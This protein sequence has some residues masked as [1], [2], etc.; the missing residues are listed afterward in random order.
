MSSN[1]ND[2]EILLA[3]IRELEQE[4]HKLKNRALM[5]EENPERVKM[6]KDINQLRQIEQEHGREIYYDNQ[7]SMAK[8]VCNYIVS[9]CIIFQLVLA[10]PQTGK[11]GCML[12]IIELLL[13]METN[14][15]PENIF[16]ITGLSDNEWVAQ[17]RGR[18]PLPDYNVIHRGQFNRSK[19]LFQNLENAV[20]FIDECQIATKQKMSIDKLLQ[21]IG[22][23]D[24]QYLKDNNINIIEFSATPNT[25]LDD[26]EYWKFS[27]KHV[28][29][30]GDG[31][32]GHSAL[33]RDCR[34]YQAHDL[35]I[36]DDPPAGLCDEEKF[37]LLRKIEPA[38]NEMRRIK[39]VMDKYDSPKNHIIRLP[40]GSKGSTVLKRLHR[41][42]SDDKYIVMNCF[43]EKD[44][45]SDV[46]RLLSEL[47]KIPKKNTILA[48]KES[49]RCAVTFPNKHH[50]GICYERVPTSVVQDDVI[51]QGLSGRACGYDVHDGMVVF[52]NVKSIKRY[53]EM[54]A[55]GFTDRSTFT[56][57]GHKSKKAT[58]LHPC[59][60]SNIGDAAD[61]GISTKLN[62]EIYISV[63]DTYEEA[64]DFIKSYRSSKRG[65]NRPKSKIGEFVTASRRDGT[66]VYSTSEIDNDRRWGINQDTPV[67][68]HACYEDTNN[69]NTL[70]YVCVYLSKE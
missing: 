48:I 18:L 53:V 6:L 47:S 27:K 13:L 2:K 42:F 9:S 1:N 15:K 11:T 17:T 28:M 44:P 29:N 65:P 5:A 59:G 70:K 50:I 8:Q 63:Y 67:R 22:L 30:P 21:G 62:S 69:P 60:Y 45:L 16:V 68:F 58:H 49:A 32:K 25:T 66:R 41:V 37:A 35:Y 10:M 40:S 57:N 20:I 31:Y 54:V 51:V 55:S 24:V 4:N 39:Y 7:E 34:L 36:D 33:I 14:V 3:R 64:S 19:H 61:E 46:Q 38:M 26:I 56:Y 12:A 43:I 23:K 52:T